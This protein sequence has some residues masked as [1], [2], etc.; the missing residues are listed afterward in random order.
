MESDLLALKNLGV[1]SV[2]WLHAIGIHNQSE[3]ERIGAI[4]AYNRIRER[5]IKVSKVL[6]Y[7]LEAALRDIHWSEL[8][9]NEKRQL[10]A[11]AERNCADVE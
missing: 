3:L 2:N 4:Q 9:P 10:V 5:G 6:L 1:T 11:L 8:D 7:A